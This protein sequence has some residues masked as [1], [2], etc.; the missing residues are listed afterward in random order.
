MPIFIAPSNTFN[1]LKP[2]YLLCC[3]VLLPLLACQS[4]NDSSSQ[5]GTATEPQPRSTQKDS[6]DEDDLMFQLSAL[7]IA[8][9]STQLEKEQNRIV[10][11]AIDEMIPLQQ[12][13]SGLFYHIENE[14]EGAPIQW[15]DYLQAHYKGYFLDGEVF[16][17][18]RPKGKPME[19][20]VGNMIPAWN[21]ALQLL[22]PG[23]RMLL[24]APSS[25]AYGEEG[26]QDKSGEEVVPP[27]EPLVFELEVVER[28]KEAE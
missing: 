13:S 11:Y 20:Y 10:N 18:S 8:S 25:L 24:F 17:A 7:L 9:P 4:G 6:V 12:T 28:L 1:M 21:E 26:V 15:G 27:N 23:G 16:D 19:F 14:G 2:A 5:S 22:K 3:S